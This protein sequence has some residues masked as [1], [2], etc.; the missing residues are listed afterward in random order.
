M[1]SKA[2]CYFLSQL[3]SISFSTICT[4]PNF[5]QT[6]PPVRLAMVAISLGEKRRV[7]DTMRQ[8]VTHVA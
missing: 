6:K 4:I 1:L 8:N 7:M 2:I 5:L 3:L